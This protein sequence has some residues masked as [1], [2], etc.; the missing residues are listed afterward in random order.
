MA[1]L[2]DRTAYTPQRGRAA[3]DYYNQP[4][5]VWVGS[6]VHHDMPQEVRTRFWFVLLQHPDLAP[7]LRVRAHATLLVRLPLFRTR[8]HTH[9][10]TRC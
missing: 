8:L 5:S 4:V 10:A 6:E 7:L 9:C 2:L 3:R 1:R